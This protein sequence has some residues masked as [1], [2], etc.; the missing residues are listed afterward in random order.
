M[1]P[2]RLTTL[3]RVFAGLLSVLLFATLAIPLG[4]QVASESHAGRG[5]GLG[6]DVAHETTLTGT[7]QEVATKRIAG[8]PAGTHLLIA[9]PQGT[10][11]AHVG[12]YLT[13]DAQEALH[14]G[15]PV[16]VIG[17]METLHGKHVLLVRQLIFGGR[18][19]TIR[20]PHGFL[21]RVQAPRAASSK[22]DNTAGTESNGGSR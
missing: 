22:S 11:D 6:Y 16:Q 4:A 2:R 1:H 13:K 12:P 3:A 18:I 21:V 19:V 9:G 8:G 20:S 14:F 15:T 10:V 17:A 5:F 7:I